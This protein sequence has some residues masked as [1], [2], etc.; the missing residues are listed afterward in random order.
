MYRASTWFHLYPI[1]PL[2]N[3]SILL[4]GDLYLAL[5]G[6]VSTG[7]PSAW[8]LSESL[9]YGL[10][11]TFRDMISRRRSSWAENLNLRISIDDLQWKT[12]IWSIFQFQWTQKHPALTA[13]IHTST[14]FIDSFVRWSPLGFAWHGLYRIRC[15]M[16]STRSFV[17]WSRGDVETVERKRQEHPTISRLGTIENILIVIQNQL[18]LQPMQYMK[19]RSMCHTI[20]AKSSIICIMYANDKNQKILLAL[21]S[22]EDCKFRSPEEPIDEFSCIVAI[23]VETEKIEH[24]WLGYLFWI[25]NDFTCLWY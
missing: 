21:N 7:L 10:H 18:D 11:E 1:I 23:I 2:P 15:G 22:T 4:C 5:R 9:W 20:W 13:P 16:V 24:G 12:V 25:K 19:R 8:S 3:S 14:Q 17:A 6:M